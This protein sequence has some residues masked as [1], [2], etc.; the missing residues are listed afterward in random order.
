MDDFKTC[1]NKYTSKFSARTSSIPI[2]WVLRKA[3]F[4]PSQRISFLLENS[5][6]EEMYLNLKEFKK[7]V[8]GTAAEK[9]IDKPDAKIQKDLEKAIALDVAALLSCLPNNIARFHLTS[10]KRDLESLEGKSAGRWWDRMGKKKSGKTKWKILRQ[11]GPFLPPPYEAL[12]KKVTL[13]F[14]GKPVKLSTKEDKPLY[15]SAEEAAVFFAKRLFADKRLG[16]PDRTSKDAVF[17]KNFYRDWAT[18]LKKGNAD[19]KKIAAK[20]TKLARAKNPDFSSIDFSGIV[21]HLE[22]KEAA[23]KEMDKEA[24][25]AERVA[26]KLAKDARDSIFGWCQV[27]DVSYPVSYAIQIPGIFIGKSGQPKRGK[28]K[29]RV[30]STD[31]TL[32]LSPKKDSPKAYGPDGRESKWKDV[33][34]EKDSTW[35]AKYKNN[36]TEEDIYVRINRNADPWVGDNDFEKF[37]KARKLGKII[38]KIRSAYRKGYKGKDKLLAAAVFLLD[39]VAIR[40]GSEGDD[41]SGTTGLTTLLCGNI[42]DIKTKSFV[43]DFTG[44][45][46]IPFRRKIDIDTADKPVLEILRNAC[47]GKK[48]K[49]QIWKSVTPSKLNAYLKTIGKNPDLTA[50]VFRTWTASTLLSEMLDEASIKATDPIEDKKEAYFDANLAAAAALNHKT[51]TDTAAAEEKLQKKIDEK[52]AAYAKKFVTKKPTPKQRASHL[53][54]L[55]KLK[56]QLKVKQEN[57]SLSTSRVNYMDPRIT[58]AWAKKYEVPLES[59]IGGAPLMNKSVLTNAVWAM[60]T[61]STWSFELGAPV[62]LKSKKTSKKSK[63]CGN[64]RKKADCKKNKAC[65]WEKQKCKKA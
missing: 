38:S 17:Q 12:P 39:K 22:M 37:E 62:K 53:A 5:N 1:V 59:G 9:A 30:R 55:K 27:D 48:K 60:E 63:G 16:K 31:I 61:P 21:Q 64:I 20:I 8:Q 65:K 14:E 2:L 26:K 47:K 43:L 25:K 3:F 33:V 42:K 57:I 40:P 4:D 23:K 6:F 7:K 50:K 45:S 18:I 44:K 46:S 34:V 13:K 49:D 54:A 19:E 10:G 41:G 11:N 15:V 56:Q 35:L 28:I 36:I 58:I 24:K 51:M 32:N 29:K 52:E